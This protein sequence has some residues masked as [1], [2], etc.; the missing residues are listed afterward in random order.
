MSS[1]YPIVLQGFS[2]IPGA[3]LN[4][5]QAPQTGVPGGGTGVLEAYWANPFLMME[6]MGWK[7]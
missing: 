3:S 4:H 2:I 7:T 5:Q 6:K 1:V